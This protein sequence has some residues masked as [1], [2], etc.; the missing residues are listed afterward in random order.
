MQLS[1][2]VFEHTAIISLLGGLISKIVV[3]NL[4]TLILKVFVGFS[5]SFLEFVGVKVTTTLSIL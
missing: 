1:P 5:T 4:N 3:L 2:D